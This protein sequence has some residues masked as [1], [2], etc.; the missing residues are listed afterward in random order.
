MSCIWI[1]EI[2]CVHPFGCLASNCLS[3]HP[4]C[5][6]KTFTLGIRCKHFNQILL[7]RPGLKTPLTST[8]SYHFQNCWWWLWVASRVE[9]KTCWL[10]FLA[11][12]S[13]LQDEFWCRFEAIHL[14]HPDITID[15]WTYIQ[16]RVCVREQ[17]LLRSFPVKFL[18]WFWWNLISC[19]DLWVWKSLC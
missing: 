5:M 2:S 9:N 8:I 4:P 17:K 18:S 7:C 16:D 13:S 15:L 19:H 14:E 11:H 1:Y 10:Y 3:V 12:F 6:A